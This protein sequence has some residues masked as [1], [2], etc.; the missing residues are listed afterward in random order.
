M[1]SNIGV[2]KELMSDSVMIAHSKQDPL[3]DLAILLPLG[4]GV[5]SELILRIIV[6]GEVLKDGGAL[7]DAEI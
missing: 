6:L 3:L 2:S 7:E 4:L 1:I 5:K